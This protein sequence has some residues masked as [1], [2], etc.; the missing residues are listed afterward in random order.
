MQRK[1]DGIYSVY[2]S[3]SHGQGLAMM[4]FK[5]NSI[6]GVDVVGV[7]FDGHYS[8]M[9]D[10][11]LSVDLSSTF[12]PNAPMIQGGIAGPGGDVF[13]LSFLLDADFLN[14]EFVR[15]ETERGPVNVRLVLLRGL[16]E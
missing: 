8:T 7:R 4:V 12:P 3:G 2:L 15:I 11:R 16:N 10:G 6:V 5:D 14:R 9:D 13:K 1:I